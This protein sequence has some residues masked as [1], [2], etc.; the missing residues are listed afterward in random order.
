MDYRGTI[1]E[2]S[3]DKKFDLAAFGATARGSRVSKV[4]ESHHTPWLERWTLVS[5]SVPEERSEE[6]AAW[7]ADSLLSEPGT[8]YA[9]YKTKKKH[10]IV[11]P[12]K[13]FH[14]DRTEDEYELVREYG[15]SKGVP[16]HQLDFSPEVS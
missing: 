9:D 10:Y 5:V 16:A 14:I 3:L 15:L 7:L 1:I 13:V 6:L 11:F 12:G 8:W 4:T 2:E